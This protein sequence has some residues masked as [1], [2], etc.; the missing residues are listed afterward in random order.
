MPVVVKPPPG[1]GSSSARDS[2]SPHEE[3]VRVC[4]AAAAAFEEGLDCRFWPVP[5]NSFTEVVPKFADVVAIEH[6]DRRQAEVM[7]NR[8]YYVSTPSTLW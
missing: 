8:I 1:Q 4:K 2:V 6:A 5:G 7:A 3:F